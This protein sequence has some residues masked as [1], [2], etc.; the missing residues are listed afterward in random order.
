[1]VQKDTVSKN[2][3]IDKYDSNDLMFENLKDNERQLE[4]NYS[5]N[6]HDM[7]TV[8]F[9][10][11]LNFDNSDI[12]D[13]EMNYIEQFIYTCHISSGNLASCPF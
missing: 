9:F 1:M 11:Q 10:D 4:D 8:H 7:A 12:D 5:L 3:N 6:L 2:N 13:N